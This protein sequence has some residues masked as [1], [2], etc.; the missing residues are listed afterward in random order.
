VSVAQ[1]LDVTF[2]S[3]GCAAAGSACG[4][5]VQ[6]GRIGDFSLA[7]HADTGFVEANP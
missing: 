6:T 2:N 1:S 7:V 5:G 4:S 3:R